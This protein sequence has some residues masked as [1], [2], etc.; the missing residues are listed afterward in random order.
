MGVG[1]TGGFYG[2][3]DLLTGDFHKFFD[4]KTNVKYADPLLSRDGRMALLQAAGKP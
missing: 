2:G 1:T 4:A 3:M